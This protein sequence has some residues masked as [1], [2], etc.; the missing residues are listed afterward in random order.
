MQLSNK[1]T[2]NILQKNVVNKCLYKVFD[3]CIER[4]NYVRVFMA[5]I[6]WL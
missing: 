3:L 6:I 5:T 4:K 1:I 2:L